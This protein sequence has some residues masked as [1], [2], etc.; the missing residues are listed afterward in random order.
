MRKKNRFLGMILIGMAACMLMPLSVSA[1]AVPYTSYTYDSYGNAVES[2]DLY[3]PEKVYTGN[4]FLAEDDSVA[5]KTMLQ[6]RDMYAAADDCLY[7]LDSGNS[8]VLVL[9]KNMQYLRTVSIAIDGAMQEFKKAEGIYVD[10]KGNIYIADAGSKRVLCADGQGQVFHVIDKVD[11]EQFGNGVEFLP[12]KLV[13]D[14]AGNLYVQSTGTYSGLVVFNASFEFSGFY[15]ADL[16]QTTT[17][18]LSDFFW[19]QFMTETQREAMANYVPLEIQNFDVTE[20][21][22]L[23]TITPSRKLE[24]Q[25]IKTEIDSIR[26][27]NPKGTDRLVNKMS[28]TAW[29]ALEKDACSLNFVDICYDENGFINVIDNA[30]GKIYQFDTNMNLITAFGALGDYVGTFKDPVAIEILNDKLIVLDKSKGNLTV[31]SLTATGE[32]VHQALMLY[33]KGKYTEAI[34]PWLEVIE[35]NVNFELAYVGVGSALYNL[36]DY[37][38]AMKYFE[39]GRDS[40]KYS[41]AYAGYRNEVLR[42]NMGWIFLVVVVLSIGIVVYNN[43]TAGQPVKSYRTKVRNK[44][45]LPF[46]CMFH[47]GDGFDD[48][49]FN[50]KTSMGMS[51]AILF[52]LVMLFITEQRFTG[53][54]IKMLDMEQINL[55]KTLLVT[56]GVVLLFTIANVAFCVLVDGKAKTKE[57]WIVTNYALLPYICTGYLRVFLSNF[58]SQE[59]AVFLDVLNVVG[60]LWSLIILIAGLMTFHQYGIGKTLFSLFIT[61]VAMVL[62]IFL[63]FLCYSLFLQMAGTLNTVFNEIMFRMRP[64]G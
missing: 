52:A 26:Y 2:A 25:Q 35:E 39:L 50:N 22:F 27:L 51:I 21:G 64:H 30:H 36:K 10:D 49:K 43:K 48:L 38:G 4:S 58:M 7:I 31:F 17:E 61:A 34:E 40:E 62:I 28:K 55:F 54:Q 37:K 19:K 6:P 45:E 59:E 29:K 60:I 3:E 47:P 63:I 20:K 5:V 33:H 24:A 44:Y 46:H 15:G 53:I 57:V 1:A 14:N 11:S 18:A 16:V 12:R 56:V 32:K 8:R 42:K 41:E 13:M 23:Y 9:D